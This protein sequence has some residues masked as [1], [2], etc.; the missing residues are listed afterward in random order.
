MRKFKTGDRVVVARGS[1]A[2]LGCKG[3]VTHYGIAGNVFVLLDGDTPNNL[4]WFYEE[5]LDLLVD[6]PE[7]APFNLCPKQ[8]A[9]LEAATELSEARIKFEKALDALNNNQ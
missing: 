5:S 2:K 7:T 8:L 3:E 6:T 9:V 4:R 1:N